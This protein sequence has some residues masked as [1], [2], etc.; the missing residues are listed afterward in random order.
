VGIENIP[1]SRVSS[2]FATEKA[3]RSRSPTPGHRIPKANTRSVLALNMRA[4]SHPTA[5]ESS[6]RIG[7]TDRFALWRLGL[8]RQ[9]RHHLHEHSS[10]RRCPWESFS[11]LKRSISATRSDTALVS[12]P[13]SFL[14]LAGCHSERT[15]P[16]T[17]FSLGVVSRRICIWPSTFLMRISGTQYQRQNGHPDKV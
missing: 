14:T 4:T 1:T 12:C 2:P 11:A 13:R 17:S 16:Q 9:L 8:A 5:D 3:S 10:P 6:C 7:I 15:G